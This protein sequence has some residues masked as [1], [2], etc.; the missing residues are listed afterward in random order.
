MASRLKKVLGKVLSK[1]QHGFLPRKSLADAVSVVADAVEAASSSKEDWLLL[2]VNFQKA[3]D[4]VSRGYLFRVMN[5]LGVPEKFICWTKGLHAGAG[6]KI[7]VNGWL[8][9]RVEMNR[10]VRQ[11]CPLAPYLFLCALE[12][13]C[14][15]TQREM[16]GIGSTG[17]EPISEVA[18]EKIFILWSA[19]LA[20]LPR[21]DGGLGQ[22]DSKLWLD[23]LA[24]RRIDKLLNGPDGTRQWLVEK[25]EG[26]PQCWA[27]LFAH[28]S[29]GRHWHQG[30]ERW[31][32]AVK[33][34]WKSPL[35]NTPAIANSWEVEEEFIGFNRHI[36]HRGNSPFGHQIAIAALLTTRVKDFIIGG[37][38]KKEDVLKIEFGSKEAAAMAKKAY[39]AM[40]PEWRRMVEEPVTAEAVVAASGIVRYILRGQPMRLPWAVKGVAASKAA[41]SIMSLREDGKLGTQRRSHETCVEASGLQP[42]VVQGKKLIGPVADPKTRLLTRPGFFVGGELAPL[43]KIRAV[44][45]TTKGRSWRHA[46]WEEVWGKKIDWKRAID[47]RDSIHVPLKA[48]DVLLR[49]HSMNL[50]V[51]GRLD[52][53]QNRIKC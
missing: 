39:G 27:T 48:R 18:E 26:F 8:S 13:L 50:Q 4:T 16:L 53:F 37:P 43:H 38:G 5:E 3:Y 7:I 28:P 41:I 23:G 9:E 42:M 40:P 21:K 12:P 30:S 29:A 33:V 24:V 6:T 47:V 22:L 49:V 52:F 15:A 14:R 17:E 31:K 51:G 32:A 19:Y 46:E 2:L 20:C 35:A 25:V 44:L 36:K 34:F 45:T 11:G 1:E 10:G